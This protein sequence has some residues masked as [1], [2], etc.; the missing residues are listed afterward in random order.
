MDGRISW[1]SFL[2]AVFIFVVIVIILILVYHHKSTPKNNEILIDTNETIVTTYELN[3]VLTG[4]QNVHP[5]RSNAFGMA[6]FTLNTVVQGNERS[7]L[8]YRISFTN[9]PVLRSIVIERANGSL[10]KT[11]VTSD[12]VLIDQPLTTVRGVW[13]SQ[14]TTEPLTET[15]MQ[16]L[17][18]NRL[19]VSIRSGS[20]PQGEIRGLI[21]SSGFSL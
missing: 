1:T 2:I 4:L 19:Y 21:E 18:N 16:D 7:A 11:L 6:F 14:D 10:V 13:S 17:L 5:V 20:H 9:I 3:A 8:I 15:L 12:D